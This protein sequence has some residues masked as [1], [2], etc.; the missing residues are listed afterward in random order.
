[1]R[2][3]DADALVGWLKSAGSYLKGLEN[4]KPLTKAIGVIINHTEAMPTI[5]AVEVVRCRDCKHAREK[6]KS[7]AGY[8]YD[9]VKICCHP[10]AADNCW[11]PVWENHYCSYGERKID[12]NY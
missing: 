10:E 12:A 6:T 2:L 3:I 5:D 1:M 9:G 4:H 8:L 7:E 11:N